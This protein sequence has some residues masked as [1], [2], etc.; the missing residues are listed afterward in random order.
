MILVCFYDKSNG[1]ILKIARSTGNGVIDR[2]SSE[3]GKKGIVGRCPREIFSMS[4][5]QVRQNYRV[6]S[7]S[8]GFVELEY[9]K[10]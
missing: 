6:K 9:A 8:G 3:S 10:R 1:T 7:E 5:D 2:H 4:T